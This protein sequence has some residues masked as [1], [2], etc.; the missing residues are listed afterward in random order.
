M[1]RLKCVCCF[2]LGHFHLNKYFGDQIK[3]PQKFQAFLLYFFLVLAYNTD[4]KYCPVK[5]A[6]MK[7]Q[8]TLRELRF[9]HTA[10]FE[11]KGNPV[12]K[13]LCSMGAVFGKLMLVAAA[14]SP[15]FTI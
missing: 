5:V 1:W 13:L 15:N 4:A 2:R 7:V 12:K 14:G 8:L 6:K 11:P 9:Y 3:S 10:P